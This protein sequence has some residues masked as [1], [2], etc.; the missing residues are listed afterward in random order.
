[1][2]HL[3]GESSPYLRQHADNPVD[4]YPWGEAAFR[5]AEQE[6]KP[7]FLSIG[8]STCHW[9]H[10]MA[11]ESFED[12]KTA[13]LLNRD[14]VCIKVDR[15]ERPDV[16]A[17][18]M[19]A[20][21]AL[22][23][24]G[25]WPLTVFLTPQ[26]APFFAAT[27][28]PPHSR[29]GQ[30]GLAELL[31]EIARAWREERARLLGAGQTL[32]RQLL[33]QQ[34]QANPEAPSIALLHSAIRAFRKCYDAR[35]GGFG[36][37]PKF[38]RPQDLLFLLRFAALEQDNGARAMAEHTLEQMARG[39]IFDHIGGGFAR[40]STDEAWL[41]PHFEKTLYD[42]ALLAA[43]Y[44]EAYALTRKELYCEI[45]TRTLDYCLR[46]LQRPG[47][48]FYCGQDA[49]SGG[50]EGLYYLLTP[51]E[52]TQVLG[53]TDGAAFC[54]AFDI[55]QAG[56][57]EGQN[58]P[59]RIGAMRPLPEGG[60]APQRE[61]LLNY[62]RKRISLHRDEKILTAWNAMLIAA[63]ARGAVLLARHDWL[64][65]ASQAQDFLTQTLCD[66]HARPLLSWCAG[67]A[68]HPGQ[69][70]D[71]AFQVLALL[72]LYAATFDA[73]CLLRADALAQQLCAHFAD[74]AGG[75]FTT[76][77]DAEALLTRPKELYDGATPSAN[78]AAALGFVWLANLTGKA[79]WQTQA[80][81]QLSFLCGFA[82]QS[83]TAE[84]GALL[85]ALE[86][87][88][89]GEQL[90]CASASAQPPRALL[91]WRQGSPQP[92]PAALYKSPANA[93]LLARAAP[94]TAD[95]PLPASGALYYRCAKGTC[96]QPTREP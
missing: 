26:R 86:A 89:P 33:A 22:T 72:E 9:C 21:Q 4:W 95:F 63:L 5:R 31:P 46:E 34:A 87:L 7:I 24:A 77:D 52:V 10:V 65:A 66:A 92:C 37:A 36:S 28:L 39:G 19:A 15:E 61:K 79:F 6:D 50:K 48:G 41:I 73:A 43:C 25:G 32:T 51:R 53:D 12:A 70:G 8:Y 49:D 23:G 55:T 20:C 38:P 94:F 74:P 14:F 3:Q 27:Y 96:Q 84:G 82:R 78:A 16:D 71:Y 68:G 18:Y 17:V 67:Q 93:E 60:M 85:A 42:N 29:W 2:N 57:F 69:L 88:R 75:F 45:A 35:W 90:L 47:G 40:Y 1:M 11:E 13:A 76:A 91:V 56:N 58:V 64:R 62:R 81:Q 83:P 80:E 54:Q 44:L 30:M 59:N